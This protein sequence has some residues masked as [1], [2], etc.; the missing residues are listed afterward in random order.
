M[1]DINW[2]SHTPAGIARREALDLLD[3]ANQ[4]FMFR[5]V[6]YHSLGRVLV[7]G[8]GERV[9]A[10]LARMPD[11][12]LKAF[13]LITDGSRDAMDQSRE[14]AIDTADTAADVAADIYLASID[15]LTGYLGQFK[16]DVER[17]GREFDLGELCF[18]EDSPFFD[19]V[20]DLHQPPVINAQINAV[21][22]FSPGDS[23]AETAAVV[24]A[25]D[26]VGEF[27]KPRYFAYDADICAHGRSGITGCTRCIDACPADAIISIGEQVEVNPFL[28]QGGGVCATACPTG[29][30]TYAYPPVD[31]V[32]T[33]LRAGIRSLV[34]AGVQD[35][36]VLI[37][38]D[39]RG[40]ELTEAACE[41]LPEN[42]VPLGVEEVGSAGLDL[43]LSALSWG[44]ATVRILAG[45]N[46]PP[47]VAQEL[48]HQIKVGQHFL[49][50]TG[51]G[52]NRI[53]VIQPSTAESFVDE[54]THS[55]TDVQSV[56]GA[57]TSGHAHVSGKRNAIRVALDHLA[58]TGGVSKDQV[59]LPAGSPFGEIIVDA[60]ACTLCMSCAS[61]C[62]VDAITPGGDLP[63]LRFSEFSCVQC[64]TCE[65][66][67]PEHAITLSPRYLFDNDARMSTR[68]LH[69][70]APFNCVSC[71]K[72]FATES[73]MSRMREKLAGHWMFQKPEQMRRLEMCEDCR[74][75]DMLMSEGGL[76]PSSRES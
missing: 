9:A 62:P 52:E 33:S 66:A 6:D 10:M 48:N 63:A 3:Q 4:D 71:G 29:A 76:S 24:A 70:E 38:D 20:F 44:A 55:I 12:T 22:Y 49:Q 72:P 67:C 21:G 54:L 5:S 11:R 46:V 75:K 42:V 36:C 17:D 56:D 39:T 27:Q 7:T 68:T 16:V 65:V 1:S 28:C 14:T 18:G 19:I 73:V 2:P 23:V 15:A 60:Q 61:V 45:D 35:L 47:S 34:D 51:A 74:V 8:P 40:K 26:L 41:S 25:A 57:T 13:A 37:H 58:R 64:G 32:M 53:A 43:W 31:D 30:M 50:A 59:E 69:E